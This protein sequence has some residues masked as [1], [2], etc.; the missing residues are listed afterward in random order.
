[1]RYQYP[2]EIRVPGLTA[3][4]TLEQLT[5]EAAPHRY[6]GGVPDDVTRQLRHELDL[7]V[8]G[9]LDYAAYFLIV[10]SIVRYA[11]SRGILC[12]RR[13][14]AAN[15][16]VCFVLGITAIDP[17]RTGLLFERFV[18]AERQEPPDIDIDFEHE[19]REEVI[20][21]DKDDIDVLRFMK[22][23]VLGLGMLGCMRQAF[24]LVAEHK[25]LQLDLAAIPSEDPVTY[26]MIRKADTLGTTMRPGTTIRLMRERRRSPVRRISICT[27]RSRR[28]SGC[29]RGT[30]GKIPVLGTAAPA[31]PFLRY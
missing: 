24:D 5:W 19:R 6:P 3:Q 28:A 25:G 16:A 22:V 11:R 9:R 27:T 14:S 10:D 20:E 12:Q 29:Q 4:Q 8:I 30:S 23:D 21:W 26:A 2:H 31:A 15:S 7:I 17:T 1:L 13:G 18:S